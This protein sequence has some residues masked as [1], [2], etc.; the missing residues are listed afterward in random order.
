M[1]KIGILTFHPYDNYGAVLQAYALQKYLEKR[2]S[3]DVEVINFVTKEQERS[4][5]VIPYNINTSIYE[6][7]VL[8]IFKVPIYCALKIRKKRFASFRNEHLNLTQEFKD[9]DS[10]FKNIPDKDIYISGSDQ[11]FNPLSQYTD[12]YY[13]GFNR[14][15]SQKIAY[16]PSF[17]I[18]EIEN[19]IDNRLRNYLKDFDAISCREEAGVEYL[20]KL[21]GIEVPC[22]CDPVLLLSKDEWLNM[23]TSPD[24]KSNYIFVYRLNGGS[25]L[26]KLAKKVSEATGLKIVCLAM[27]SRWSK[28]VTMNYSAG[29]KE[30]LGLIA[31][32]SYVVTDS[33][34]G[35]AI[36]LILNTAVIPYIAR[37]KTSSRLLTLMKKMNLSHNV[38]HDVNKFEFSEM[39][40]NTYSDLLEEFVSY[41]EDYLQ[42]SICGK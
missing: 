5:A 23:S 32:A 25:Q 33:F 7:A 31:N 37:P 22:V 21:L 8:L 12:I 38:V 29:P 36:S 16:A 34:H 24:I 40:F 35:T 18:T 9:K 26:M 4:N 17:G 1:K 15:P 41:S 2:F 13:L 30:I 27:D 39:K 28:G 3:A 42:N 20:T 6:L 19:H 10:L 11:V 14:S